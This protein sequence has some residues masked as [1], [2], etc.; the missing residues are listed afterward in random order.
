MKTSTKIR[1]LVAAALIAA[2]GAFGANQ[3]WADCSNPPGVGKAPFPTSG[4]LNLPIACHGVNAS[5][6]AYPNKDIWA[7]WWNGT[8]NVSSGCWVRMRGYNALGGRVCSATVSATGTT[9]SSGCPTS[10]QDV[11]KTVKVLIDV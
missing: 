2:A 6:A 7:T 9:A 8:C 10:G 3:A 5:G 11:A 4:V 1:Y